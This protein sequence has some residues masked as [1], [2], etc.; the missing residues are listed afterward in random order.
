[1]RKFTVL[2][3]KE[4]KELITPQILLPFVVS[5][6]VFVFL[7][8]VVGAQSDRGVG[9]AV[10]VVDADRTPVSEAIID[11]L[12]TAGFATTVITDETDAKKVAEEARDGNGVLVIGIPVGFGDGIGRGEPQR[13]ESYTVMR[14]FSLLATRDVGA[15]KAVVAAVNDS[16][17]TQLIEGLAPGTDAAA[18]QEPV[19][20]TEHVIVGDRSADAS[21]EE[22]IGF[23][24]S[25]TTFI[26][27]ILFLVIIFAAQMIATTIAA[28]KENKTLETL[29]ASPIG[30][31]QLVTA[32]MVAA[33]LIALL[34]AGAYM[35]GLRYY[36][37]SIATSFG[38]SA[39]QQVGVGGDV[40][41]QLGLT[42]GVTDYALLGL[43]LFV[44]I[45]VAL[46]AAVILGAFAENVRSVQSLL[47][48]L[49]VLIMIPYFLTMFVDLQTA[50]PVMRWLVL[51]IPFAHP[52]RAAPNLF[53]G[54]YAAVWSGIAYE[55]LWFVG[56][57][58]VATRI[59]ASD[60]ILTLKLTGLKR[61]ALWRR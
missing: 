46:A 53:L 33:A 57:T 35:I 41:A 3:R 14:N 18:I 23:I 43:S 1:V 37:N 48:P 9:P 27:I 30:R 21:A 56:L 17:S 47:T 2:L 4:L 7:G 28:E 19:G 44:G 36:M 5:M 29:L 13:L 40:M 54:D 15:L 38:D 24:T 61:G 11:T 58:W 55:A 22:V 25:Q 51:G 16:M 45:L 10:T 12:G 60:R 6:L 52:F 42:L 20:L 32:K 34:S 8:N 49:M 31:G 26:P 59:F 39:A 50:S